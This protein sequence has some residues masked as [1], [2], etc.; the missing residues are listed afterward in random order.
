MSHLT[1]EQLSEHLDGATSAATRAETERHLA[2]CAECRAA[3]ADL[4]SLDASLGRVL[5]HDPGE[6]YFATFADR[7]EDR[8][9]A[10]GLR[11]AQARGTDERE[12]PW[13][14]W[15]RSP[16]KL[17]WVGAMA[18]V[19]GG[20][21]I[22]LITSR[23]DRLNAIDESRV[24]RES[25]GGAVAPPVEDRDQATA[26]SSRLE[27][28]APTTETGNVP[29]PERQMAQ[30]EPGT[31]ASGSMQSKESKKRGKPEA[32]NERASGAP[33]PATLDERRA[34]ANTPRPSGAAP[35]RLVQMK[36]NAQGD[37]VPVQSPATPTPAA[38]F[39]APPAGAAV[40]PETGGVHVRKE[41]MATPLAARAKDETTQE[42]ATP[43][44][45]SGNVSVDD[46]LQ[47]GEI[48][49]CG[50]VFDASRRA[51]VGASV[52]LGGMGRVAFT[53]SDGRFCMSAPAGDHELVVTAV[54]FAERRVQVRVA[55][56]MA[57]VAVGLDAVS[58]LGDGAALAK[59]GA[60]GPTGRPGPTAMLKTESADPFAA[61][62]DSTRNA[63]REAQRLSGVA[64]ESKTAAACELAA[65][66]W[67]RVLADLP[68]SGL[69]ANLARYHVAE[70]RYGAWQAS[71]GPARA[72]SASRAL[73]A[74]LATAPAGA[75][76][77]LATRWRA[78]LA[79]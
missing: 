50:S 61:L 77:D 18:A 76:R 79:R 64:L 22:V 11:G 78:A 4:E 40:T 34:D 14:D 58:V 1:P 70:G 73:D 30:A 69:A 35:E 43:G 38:R 17:A 26:S 59:S 42:G 52:T 24:A 9:R 13:M 5:T 3:L 20:A 23:E 7:V 60:I 28:P 48:L 29:A 2:G 31:G 63:A 15:L 66:W 54:G 72:S 75:E 8:L 74:F 45:A 21:A 67:E 10:D 51:V 44:A 6:A 46:K 65:E 71:P 36:R 47:A 41:A 27:T 37:W 68:R 19:I 57:N 16:R 33:A 62:P 56:E 32:A 25:R 12:R 39:A 55:G 49:L 53:G